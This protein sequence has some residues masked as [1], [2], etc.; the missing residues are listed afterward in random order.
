MRALKGIVILFVSFLLFWSCGQQQPEPEPT[1]SELMRQ[2]LEDMREAREAMLA[3]EVVK[4]NDV[5]HF[6]EGITSREAL[7]TEQFQAELK[8]FEMLYDAMDK[9]DP[10]DI[11]SRYQAVVQFCISCHERYCP[12]P[13]RAIKSLSIEPVSSPYFRLNNSE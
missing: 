2:R 11:Q 1:L 13:L 4:I 6:A 3:G 12:G 10:A 8:A 7:S 5:I 9:F